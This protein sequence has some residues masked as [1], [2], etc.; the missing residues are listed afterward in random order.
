[1]DHG[2]GIGVASAARNL[3]YY[4]YNTYHSASAVY[5]DLAYSLDREV[6]E[7]ALR[8]AG[9]ARRQPQEA[10]VAH[11][12]VRRISKEQVRPRQKI[13]AFSVLGFGVIAVL[14]VLVLMNYIQLT[15]LSTETV[16]LKNQL[17][18]LETEHVTL[19]TQY[20]QMY[21]L[22]TV[23]T[24]AEEAGMSKPSN[25]QIYYVDLSDGDSAVV[26]QKEEPDILSRLLTS[27]N[28]GVYA[29]VEYFE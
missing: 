10:A 6:R 8:H 26:Y 24:A 23:K 9:E 14:A 22:E 12:Q 27:L 28:H 7:Y 11:P 1:M 17:S 5:G 20:E 21:D 19:T 2:G 3:R 25:S 4:N 15:E 16:A 29:V 18:A 13:S